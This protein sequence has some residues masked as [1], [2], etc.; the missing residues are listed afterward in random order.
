MAWRVHRCGFRI[1]EIPILFEQRVAGKSKIDSSE[2]YRA[3]WHV[4]ATALR[5][6]TLRGADA[7]ASAPRQV[8][9]RD[10]RNL[11]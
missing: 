4:L 1:G 11:A 3:A 7:P 10:G 5:P 8:S 2:I 9:S 6:P